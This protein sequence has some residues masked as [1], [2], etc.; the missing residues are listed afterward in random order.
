[1]IDNRKIK[2][3]PIE[4]FRADQSYSDSRGTDPYKGCM[5]KVTFTYKVRLINL[6][7]G[8]ALVAACEFCMPWNVPT[9]IKEVTFGYFEDSQFGV[10]VAENWITSKFFTMEEREGILLGCTYA[11]EDTDCNEDE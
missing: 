2:L 5:N 4:W 11:L 6:K 8:P 10:E 7:Y 9:N 1:M 3:P